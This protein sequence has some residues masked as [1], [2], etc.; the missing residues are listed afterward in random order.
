MKKNIH[1]QYNSDAVV[2][3]SSCGTTYQ[4][5]TIEQNTVVAICAKCH[6]FY[7]GEQQVLVDTANK[8]SSFKERVNKADELKKKKEEIEKKRAEREKAKIGVIGA[9]N[10]PRMSLR[11]LLKA[12]QK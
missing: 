11:D 9:T 1:P 10:E 6:P 4:I 2:T 7:T 5:G 12:S 3:C 8:I